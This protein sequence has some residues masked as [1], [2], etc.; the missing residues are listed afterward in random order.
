MTTRSAGEDLNDALTKQQ[1][2]T[3]QISMAEDPST[4]QATVQYMAPARLQVDPS[5]THGLPPPAVS[6]A[7][8]D[9]MVAAAQ[10]EAAFDAARRQ[11]LPGALAQL[12]ESGIERAV[13]VFT[14]DP[15][16]GQIVVRGRQLPP[17]AVGFLGSMQSDPLIADL[18]TQYNKAVQSISVLKG[19]LTEK[20][21]K[22]IDKRLETITHKRKGRNAGEVKTPTTAQIQKV[23][24]RAHELAASRRRA[25]M[26]AQVKR[27]RAERHA[28][29]Q[30]KRPIY[31]T[32]GTVGYNKRYGK[33]LASNAVKAQGI[34]EAKAE[35]KKA[36][37]NITAENKR[38]RAAVA[39][40]Y[41]RKAP[42]EKQPR[43]QQ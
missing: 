38:D 21:K 7:M 20:Q 18:S 36:R 1:R 41:G 16:T 40:K 4:T 26:T 25:Q 32:E 23:L 12:A 30:S 17:A 34:A 42:R 28:L 33:K 14:R 39:Q 29:M 5:Y 43:I 3:E 31:T 9:R 22:Y 11:M 24:M 37:A 10:R 35:A 13:P 27:A 15:N 19:N 8:Y 2:I 6:P